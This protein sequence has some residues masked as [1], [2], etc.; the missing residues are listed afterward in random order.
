M[1]P[2]LQLATLVLKGL[3]L[4]AWVV[5]FGPI[6]MVIAKSRVQTIRASAVG[7]ADVNGKGNAPS[8]VYRASHSVK[9]GKLTERPSPDIGTLYDLF[10]TAV[11]KY[12]AQEVLGTRTLLE[13]KMREG[14]RFPTKVFGKTTWRTYKQ[15]GKIMLDFGSGLRELGLKPLHLKEGEAFDTVKGNHTILMYEDTCAE[16]LLAA[17]GAFSQSMVVATAYATLGVS[18]IVD[19]VN[20]AGISII[21]C[22]YSAVKHVLE[23]RADM[24]TLKY[25]IYT[26][27][28][29]PPDVT[30]HPGNSADVKVFSFDEVLEK[31]EQAHH[32]ADPPHPRDVAI[33]MYTSGSTGKPK[34]VVVRHRQIVAMLGAIEER[35]GLKEGETLVGY[36]P[37]AHILEMQMEFFLFGNGG[38]IG[39]ADPKTLVA[40]P[41]KCEPTGGLAE[42]RPTVMGA[43]P[44]VWEVIKNGA[45]AKVKAGGAAKSYLFHSALEW[46]KSAIV[47]FRSTP[48]F[49][50]LVFAK[51]KEVVGGRLKIA[52]SGGGAISSSVQEWIRAV[53]NMPLIQGYGL[54]ET[55]AGL[56]IQCP[57]D[58]RVGVVG[59][60]IVCTEVLFHSEL[61]ICDSD[62]KPYLTNDTDHLGEAVIS[63]GE[64]WTRGISITDGYYKMPEETKQEFDAEGWFHT[65]DIGV[66]LPDG[67][68]K[69]VDRKKNLVKLKGGEYIAL[70]RMNQAYNTCDIVNREGGGAC[71][72]GDGDMDRPVAIVQIDDHHLAG[73]AE[74]AGISETDPEKLAKNEKVCDEVTK[75]LNDAGKKISPPLSSLETL[76]GVVIIIHPWTPDEGTLTASLKIVP[77]KIYKKHDKELQAVIPKGKR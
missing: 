58:W 35:T 56:S 3:D 51:F 15:C 8:K 33:M 65:G 57:D 54:T 42:F 11:K 59:P 70:E 18:S 4:F 62:N 52:L 20:E 24:P 34:G 29:I 2:L 38:Q 12:S 28:M 72:Y 48:V 14:V 75:M 5:T 27:N 17:Q 66:M 39:Y 69:I 67:S 63:R 26:K 64:I 41:G 43:V 47:S 13:N 25:V 46:K 36:L 61:E 16:W 50:K 10:S 68:I 45:E 74:K 23:K 44:K 6:W 73:I 30:A 49:D 22:N 77:K 9:T 19:A 76:A 1:N 60:P 21:C 37:L 53:F 31:G 32:A 40:G 7:E 71:S 55:C